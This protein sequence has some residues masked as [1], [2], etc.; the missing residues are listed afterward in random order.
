VS[1]HDGMNLG[2][3]IDDDAIAHMDDAQFAEYWGAMGKAVRLA[4][5]APAPAQPDHGELSCTG[6]S[7]ERAAGWDHDRR[8]PPAAVR[9][10]FGFGSQ[11]IACQE[12]HLAAG[13]VAE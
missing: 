4:C 13:M 7:V 12:G 1:Y 8:R 2:D 9:L 6:A 10:R 5:R 11:A 3:L